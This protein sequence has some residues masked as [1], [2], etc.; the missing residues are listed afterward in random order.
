[1][2]ATL[3]PL[4][5]AHFPLFQELLDVFEAGVKATDLYPNAC[6]NALEPHAGPVTQLLFSPFHRNVFL[7]CST[8]GSVRVYNLV[9]VR[10]YTH[11]MCMRVL[12]ILFVRSLTHTQPNALLYLEPSRDYITGASWSPTRPLVFAC[13]DAGGFVY[14]F[15]L[16]KV[17][18]HVRVYGYIS[19]ARCMF[20][21][22]LIT[23]LHTP[24]GHAAPSGDH[25]AE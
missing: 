7:S 9:K 10:E 21:T 11:F 17:K 8:D 6:V 22:C 24:P 4:P 19:C 25:P 2:C 20:T 3:N 1:M 16:A 23:P 14:I 13:S 12:Y 18:A 15:D 5:H